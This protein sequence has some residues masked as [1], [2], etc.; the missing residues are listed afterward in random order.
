MPQGNRWMF[1]MGF[2]FERRKAQEL[3]ALLARIDGPAGKVALWD[4][5]RERPLGTNL[6]WSSLPRTRFTDGT[7]FDD[8]TWFSGGSPGVFVYHDWKVGKSDVLVYGF[9]ANT[10]QLLGGDLV[11]LGG[12]LYRLRRDAIANGLGVARL[13][14]HRGLLTA[15]E[16]GE[17]V[18]RERPTSPFRLMDDDQA[19]R[20]R[21]V[22]GVAMFTLR[23]IEAL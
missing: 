15:L 4:F 18:V 14:L 19:A 5:D 17:T 1:D 6:D 3:E 12:Y 7:Q 23:F 22:G 9:P 11:G 8:G 16:H 21:E 10:V 13:Y 20:S 2:R